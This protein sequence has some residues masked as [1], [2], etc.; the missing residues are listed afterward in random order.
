[1]IIDE[2]KVVNFAGGV[3]NVISAMANEFVGRGDHVSIICMDVEKGLPLFP[4]DSRV[5]FVNLAFSYGKP[6]NDMVWFLKKV[7]KES[8]RTVLGRKMS[9]FGRSIEDPKRKYFLEQFIKRLDACVQDDKPDVILSVSPEGARMAHWVLEERQINDIPVIAMCHTDPIHSG[10]VESAERLE[11]WKRCARVQV[12]LPPFVSMVRDMGV[13]NVI[14]I[15]NY[16][17][18]VSDD[19][20]ADLSQ[21]HR[22]I[23]S[24][25]R[26][27]GAS[28]R[29]HLLVEAFSL[30]ASRYPDWC[31][32]FYGSVA[33]KGYLKRVKK[34]IADKKLERQVQ[35]K[36]ESKN[37]PDI[38][39]QSDFFVCTSKFEG[40]GLA[41][42]EAMSYGLPVI[43]YRSCC[44]IA[45]VVE[46]GIGD[47][48][49]EESPDSL[50]SAMA[51]MIDR[52]D[53]RIRYGAN[54]RI[55]MR[56]YA[57]EI[58]W[59][60]WD[61]VIQEVLGE[62]VNT[63]TCGHGDASEKNSAMLSNGGV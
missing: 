1:M 41:I 55:A 22:R 7:E 39:R 33:S 19:Q 63:S 10:E 28:K 27:D 60:R 17:K 47:L 57:P 24:V 54:V 4:L 53:L 2:N 14:Q 9:F 42:A 48:L 51:R 29:Q 40:F 50:A 21:C 37:I 56:Q 46:D 59:D 13:D 18:Q 62:A 12:L 45:S 52:Q 58:I 11:A 26:I 8:L 34:A 43:A 16:V 38:L 44:S 35:Y 23:V 25:G 49:V 3:E 36:G 30:I 32:E 6:F 31:V 20:I 15:P 5:R 61:W